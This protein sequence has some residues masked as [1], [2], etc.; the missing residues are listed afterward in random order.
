MDGFW[1]MGRG[2]LVG[3]LWLARLNIRAIHLYQLLASVTYV[4][5]TV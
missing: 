4:K 3:V 5:H 2:F 1:P